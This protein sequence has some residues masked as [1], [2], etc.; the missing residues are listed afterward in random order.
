ML[1]AQCGRMG[2]LEAMD[3]A[4][5]A[6]RRAADGLAAIRAQV[7]GLTAAM[8]WRSAAADA[9]VEALAD[10]TRLLARIDGEIDRWD[11]LLARRQAASAAAG[12][13]WARNAGAGDAG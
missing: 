12:D 2:D 3:D 7:P 11:D 5:A 6:L 1:A 9:F 8:R 13:A 10:W 4:R